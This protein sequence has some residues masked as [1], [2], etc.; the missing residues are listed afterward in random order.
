MTNK[1]KSNTAKSSAWTATTHTENRCDH[2]DDASGRTAYEFGA[3]VLCSR[4]LDEALSMGEGARA[5]S[6]S[7][8]RTSRCSL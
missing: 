7:D 8:C 4:C 1:A 5:A 3:G 2:C 6:S